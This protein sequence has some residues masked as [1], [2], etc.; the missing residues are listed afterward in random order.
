MHALEMLRGLV[1]FGIA[2]GAERMLGL[3][4][5]APQRVAA[6]GNRAI[7]EIAPVAVA[8]VVQPGGMIQN[9]ADAFERDEAVRELVLDRLEFSDRL[10]ELVTLL[11]VIHG[12]F[13]RPP[14][15]AVRA[16]ERG[17]A[18]NPQQVVDPRVV[19]RQEA[20]RRAYRARSRQAPRRRARA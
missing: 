15:R 13:E 3:E 19:D 9:E 8:S 16:R 4:R 18:G 2:D 10:P 11:G 14:G 12:Q 5:H 1:L 6:E 20:R 7:G 17:D